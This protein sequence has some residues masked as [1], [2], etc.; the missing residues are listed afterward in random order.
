MYYNK[1][2]VRHE[3]QNYEFHDGDSVFRAS[4]GA[5]GVFVWEWCPMNGHNDAAGAWMFRLDNGEKIYLNGSYHEKYPWRIPNRFFPHGRLDED[6]FAS[7]P[8]DAPIDFDYPPG[9]FARTEPF[10]SAEDAN[11]RICDLLD[12]IVDEKIKTEDY[13]YVVEQLQEMMV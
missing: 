2:P 6:C 5:K 13:N 8:D 3:K 10:N 12:M 9:A 1:R 4:D 11:A 7:D